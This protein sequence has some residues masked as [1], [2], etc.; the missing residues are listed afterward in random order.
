[1]FALTRNSIFSLITR[2]AALQRSIATT[3]R[4]SS[5]DIYKIQ[6]SKEFEEKVKNIEGPVIVDFFAT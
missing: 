6:S 5:A 2:S 4:L 1:M 3:S